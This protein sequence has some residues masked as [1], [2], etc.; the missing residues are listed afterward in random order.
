MRRSGWH[1]AWGLAVLQA[2]L[3]FA[4]VSVWAGVNTW[5][6]LGP[7]GG[8]VLTLAVDS[9]NPDIV[10]A[11]TA[12]GFFASTDGART[13]KAISPLPAGS[14]DVISLVVDPQNSGTLYAAA[15]P[16]ETD[17]D[18]VFKSTD[19]GTTWLPLQSRSASA[20]LAVDPRWSNVEP[21]YGRGAGLLPKR[22]SLVDAN[23]QRVPC[24]KKKRREA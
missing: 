7:D 22:S 2:L 23:K 21:V 1:G 16:G 14:G 9:Q 15:L 6:S 13:W 4:P 5:T 10:Y 20:P 24:R 18:A 11:A 3:Q 19:G 8:S 17:G 12:G